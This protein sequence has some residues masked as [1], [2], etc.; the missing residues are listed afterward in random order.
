MFQEPSVDAV[1]ALSHAGG[2]ALSTGSPGAPDNWREPVSMTV[3]VTIKHEK[4]AVGGPSVAI[5][6]RPFQGSPTRNQY[7]GSVQ[8]VDCIISLR[9]VEKKRIHSEQ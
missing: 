8:F 9:T 7:S 1:G 6:C 3:P 5:T 4:R 2:V